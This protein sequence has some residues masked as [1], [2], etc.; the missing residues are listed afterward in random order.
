MGVPSRRNRPLPDW[1]ALRWPAWFG[2]LPDWSIRL[3]EFPDLESA[4]DR[5]GMRIEEKR[6]GGQ[7]VVRAE[8]PGIDPD[9]DVEITLSDN[10]LCIT[11]ERREETKEEREEGGY[12]S[13]F[14][15]GKFTRMVPLPA[16]ATESDVKASYAD[17]ILEIRIP[18][19]PERAAARKVPISRG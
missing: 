9:E 13:E 2:A 12:R 1:P 18:V 4:L 5:E 10:T 19:E 16:G 15:Y 6:E 8:M 11:A 7:L 3:P 17:G 14:R